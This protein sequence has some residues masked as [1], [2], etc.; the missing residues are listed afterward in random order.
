MALLKQVHTLAGLIILRI[1]VFKFG[2]INVVGQFRIPKMSFLLLSF[3]LNFLIHLIVEKSFL[4]L[5]FQQ[6]FI[7]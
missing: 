5:F 4:R 1:F 3:M 7:K 2:N 6:I